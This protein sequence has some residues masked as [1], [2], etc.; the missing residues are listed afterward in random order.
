MTFL[1]A[2]VKMKVGKLVAEAAE[3]NRDDIIQLAQSLVRVPSYSGDV[4][5]LSRIAEIIAEA[6]AGAGRAAQCHRHLPWLGGGP[7]PFIQR[8]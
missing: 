2:T 6:M 1:G 7:L 5:N 4:E 3:R 8:T